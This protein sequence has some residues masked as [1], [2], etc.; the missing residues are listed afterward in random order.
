MIS[1]YNLLN[2]QETHYLDSLIG[3]TNLWEY[4]TYHKDKQQFYDSLKVDVE[5][6]KNYYDIITENGKYEIK[7]T[8]LNVI[9]AET[10]VKNKH[11]DDSDLSYVTYLNE[12]FEGGEFFY[13]LD[14]KKFEIK[15]K[16]GLTCLLYT[17]PSPR[18]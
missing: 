8:G 18:D 13:Y 11:V 9:K 12:G 7:E 3:N 2:E 17:S 6:L 10:Q 5:K 1:F 14:K 4:R 15:P 16:I